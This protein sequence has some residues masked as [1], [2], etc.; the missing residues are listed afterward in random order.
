MRPLLID[1]YCGAGGCSMGY[2]RAGFDVVGVDVAWQSNYPF[3]FVQ[4][5]ALTELPLILSNPLYSAAHRVTA[6]HASPP[7]QD[8]SRLKSMPSYR[9]HGTGSLLPDTRDALLDTGLPWVIENVPGAAMRADYKLCGC[10]FGLPGLRRE[11]WFETSWRGFDLR[12]PCSH[13][14]NTVTVA[15]HAGGSS[16]RDGTSG[17]GDTAAWKKAMG[18]DWMTGKEL[19]QAIPPAY[20]EYLGEQLLTQLASEVA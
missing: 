9:T 19:A 6:V 17:Y 13:S 2:H 1:L 14:D 20:C 4:G 7:C 3:E 12:S 10:M 8:H 15:G 18:I 16:A 5:D 11:R